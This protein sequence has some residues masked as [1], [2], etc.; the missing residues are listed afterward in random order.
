M[1]KIV[2]IRFR[3]HG[4]INQFRP[5]RGPERPCPHPAKWVIPEREQR[6]HRETSYGPTI[7]ASVP[8]EQTQ[9]Y[10]GHHKRAWTNMVRIG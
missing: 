2:R 1:T 6:L 7:A 10:C 8:M 4:I 3:C 5:D 9:R